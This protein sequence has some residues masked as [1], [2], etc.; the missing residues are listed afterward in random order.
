MNSEA[1]TEKDFLDNLGIVFDGKTVAICTGDPWQDTKKNLVTDIPNTP[2]LDGKKVI[3]VIGWGGAMAL[4]FLRTCFERHLFTNDLAMPLD[5]IREFLNLITMTAD[6]LFGYSAKMVFWVEGENGIEQYQFELGHRF[7]FTHLVHELSPFAHLPRTAKLASN[8]LRRGASPIE[9]CRMPFLTK[10][11][12][13][14]EHHVMW[15]NVASRTPENSHWYGE[16][17]RYHHY[18]F[19]DKPPEA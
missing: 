3:A 8:L 12:E 17:S 19:F 14:T 16:N 1:T 2:V 5:R 11:G 18:D 15:F 6:N 9:L 7:V 10:H 4:G 13:D